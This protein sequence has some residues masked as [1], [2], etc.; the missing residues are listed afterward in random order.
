MIDW[1]IGQVQSLWGRVNSAFSYAYNVASSLARAAEYAARAWAQSA[2]NTAKASLN[3]AIDSARSLAQSLYQQGRAFAIDLVNRASIAAQQLIFIV[4]Y[5]L[6]SL[7][8]S[9]ASAARLLVQGAIILLMD[10]LARASQAAIDLLKVAALEIWKVLG[11]VNTF[12]EPIR[13]S[14]DAQKELL[15]F[16]ASL[17]SPDGRKKIT[18]LMGRMYNWLAQFL[19]NPIGWI[20]AYVVGFFLTMLCDVLAQGLGSL[21]YDL[22]APRTYGKGGFG[23]AFPVGPGPGPGASGLAPPVTPLYISGYRFGPGH[24]GIDLGI[25]MGQPIYAAHAGEV[26]VAGWSDIGYGFQVVLEGGGW[27]SRY[28]HNTAPTVQV[29]DHVK[30]SQN[31]A[32][33]DSTGN[34]S[35]PHCHFELKWQGKFVDPVTVLPV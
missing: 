13:E 31:I 28:G 22:P 8:N 18:D 24:P 3:S 23:G 4:K 33:G 17:F 10:L 15:A 14:W 32:I 1:L 5:E 16:L 2:V 34:S 9:A 20:A 19:E 26:L 30:Q 6:I 12:L 27:W 29:G 25:K 11:P 35:G 7:L 21:K